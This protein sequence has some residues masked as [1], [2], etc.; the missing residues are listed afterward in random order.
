MFHFVIKGTGFSSKNL[1]EIKVYE[2]TLFCIDEAGVIQ[3]IIEPDAEAYE[4]VLAEQKEAQRF[5]ELPQDSYLYLALLIY[6]SMHLSGHNL[7][8]PWIFHCMNG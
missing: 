3:E 7:G 8:P 4:T 6:M 1:Q 5:Q 2:E